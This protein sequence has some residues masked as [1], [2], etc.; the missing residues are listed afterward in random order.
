MSSCG[1]SIISLISSYGRFRVLRKLEV[2]S[3][4]VSVAN[5]AALFAFSIAILLTSMSPSR[6][7]SETESLGDMDLND[8]LCRPC[9]T[10]WFLVEA[11]RTLH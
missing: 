2:C 1:S 9:E 7:G 5:D 8:R 10:L 6:F 4:T 11:G 3:E